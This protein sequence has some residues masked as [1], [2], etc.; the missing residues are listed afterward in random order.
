ME[1]KKFDQRKVRLGLLPREA[2]W[3]VGKVLTF[4]AEKYDPWNW[5]KG[6][7][8]SRLIDAADR[9]FTKWIL[10]SGPDEE[11]G[12][13]HLAHMACCVLFLL[14]YEILG[15]GE[16]DRYSVRKNNSVQNSTD[17]NITVE[18]S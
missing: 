6:M 3:E 10:R 12:L 2:L 5:K 1:G 4:G 14:T 15:I 18:Y 8:W 16:D 7:E 13:S 11:T 9:H 17:P